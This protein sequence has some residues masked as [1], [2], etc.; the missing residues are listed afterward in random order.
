VTVAGL[1]LAAGAGRR[2]GRP[3]ALIQFGG[4]RLVDLAVATLVGAGCDPVFVVAGASAVGHVD[5]LVVWHEGWA[6]GLASSLAAG[7]VA[8]ERYA[9]DVAGRRAVVIVPVD[10]PTLAADAVR[11]VVAAG[12]ADQPRAAMATYAGVSGH[13]VF[14][15]R[16]LWTD[17]R[18]AASGDLGAKPY[19]AAL[20]GAVAYVPCD[21]L[22][23]E[24]DVDT[25]DDLV[26]LGRECDRSYAHRRESA[27]RY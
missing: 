4:H 3:K 22:G 6:D 16:S 8:L 2:F 17:V 23:G 9:R 14:L 21:G 24:I 13:P 10:Q 27:P 15:P 12:S 11:R 26:A 1:V 20:G 18:L 25:V 19:L 5:A 7:L